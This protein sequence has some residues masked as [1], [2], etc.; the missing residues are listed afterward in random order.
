MIF[1]NF[2]L[3]RIRLHYSIILFPTFSNIIYDIHFYLAVVQ[4]HTTF[5]L[6]R[7]GNSIKIRIPSTIKHHSANAVHCTFMYYVYFRKRKIER[8]KRKNKCFYFQQSIKSE[9]QIHTHK[10]MHSHSEWLLWFEEFTNIKCEFNDEIYII[11]YFS[12]IVVFASLKQ[13]FCRKMSAN[14][15][16]DA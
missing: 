4:A 7:M 12:F 9:F 3:I 11:Y 1:D 10:T 8:K 5:Y 13:W 6:F 14:W 2:S 16:I 15:I